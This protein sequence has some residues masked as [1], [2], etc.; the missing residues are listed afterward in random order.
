MFKS[1]SLKVFIH[2]AACAA[3]SLSCVMIIMYFAH[4]PLSVPV[5]FT[6]SL[7]AA[8][9][10]F[11]GM[12]TSEKHS[13]IQNALVFCAASCYFLTGDKTLMRDLSFLFCAGTISASV[14]SPMVSVLVS[15]LAR[16][17]S[18]R[19]PFYFTKM[20]RDKILSYNKIEK[21]I[22]TYR[23]VKK[24]YDSLRAEITGF[25]KKLILRIN[26]K[27]MILYACLFPP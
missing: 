8:Y 10:I 12:H 22:S 17:E 7:V 27:K 19:N 20:F 18:K 5:M 25:I 6:A 13:L 14:S 21:A 2:G 16:T 26:P 15:S 1:G 4:I 3:V 11:C 9:A 24:L 23:V